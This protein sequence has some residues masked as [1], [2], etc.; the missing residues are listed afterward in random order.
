M[1]K[2]LVD[3]VPLRFSNRSDLEEP[4]SLE[5]VNSEE[6]YVTNLRHVVP[7]V[8]WWGRAV[9]RPLLLNY[10]PLIKESLKNKLSISANTLETDS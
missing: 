9:A 6:R 7:F 1:E 5:F 10:F 8:S 4:K 2:S 3:D